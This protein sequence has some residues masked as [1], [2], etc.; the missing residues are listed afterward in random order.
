MAAKIEFLGLNLAALWRR[1]DEGVWPRE[2]TDFCETLD[3]RDEAFEF[4]RAN[5]F[6]C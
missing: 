3:E 2:L 4:L 6:L 5:L 1:D